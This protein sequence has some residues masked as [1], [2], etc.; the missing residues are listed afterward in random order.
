MGAGGKK[1]TVPWNLNYAASVIIL[2]MKT[3]HKNDNPSYCEF[4]YVPWRSSN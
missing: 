2:K 4:Y 1:M 3:N